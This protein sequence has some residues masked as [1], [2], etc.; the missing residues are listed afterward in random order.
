MVMNIKRS[1]NSKQELKYCH[2]G[3]T[4]LLIEF[5]TLVTVAGLME[6]G[7]A[8]STASSFMPSLKQ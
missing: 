3:E 2:I 6:I 5:V 8:G 1:L 4:N 7:A